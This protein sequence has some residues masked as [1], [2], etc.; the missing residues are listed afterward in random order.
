MIQW[1]SG[2]HL[3]Q[4]TPEENVPKKRDHTRQYKWP[5]RQYPGNSAY[6]LC[7]VLAINHAGT[8][9]LFNGLQVKLAVNHAVLA[10]ERRGTS[11]YIRRLVKDTRKSNS[12]E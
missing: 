11:V 8:I 5:E 3:S 6:L 2:K 10:E 9:K 4:L 7:N 12:C 1:K